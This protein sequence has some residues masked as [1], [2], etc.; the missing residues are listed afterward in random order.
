MIECSHVVG[1]FYCL[2]VDEAT[3]LDKGKVAFFPI[4]ATAVTM[5]KLCNQVFSAVSTA[6]DKASAHL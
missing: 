2:E 3:S 5:C 4:P 1:V 6:P